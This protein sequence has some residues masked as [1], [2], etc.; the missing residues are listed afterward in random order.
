MPR[1]RFRACPAGRKRESAWDSGARTWS[2]AER[3][4]YA[5]DLDDERSLLAVHD[6]ANQSK[7]DRD[8]AEWMPPAASA[9]CRY[10]ADWVTVKTRWRLSN[11]TTEHAAVKK[12]AASC[13]DPASPS[14]TPAEPEAVQHSTRYT[15]AA[16]NQPR[17][18]GFDARDED[19]AR[20]TPFGG[21]HLTMLGR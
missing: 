8:P 5:N 1:H 11:G 16:G 13:A 9:R 4:A 14:P 15:D 12:I 3:Q 7:A 19:V 17:T 20:L 10:L 2:A 21:H 18:G 6:S